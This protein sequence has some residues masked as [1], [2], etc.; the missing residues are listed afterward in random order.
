MICSK[1]NDAVRVKRALISVSDKDGLE[2][3]I[4]ALCE[5]GVEIISTGRTREAI[6]NMGVDVLRISEFT[7]AEEMMD[8]RVKTLHPKVHGAILAD[9]SNPGHMKKL[10]EMG[11]GPIDM[12]VV[13][14]YP[15]SKTVEK[16][17]VTFEEACENIDIGGPT[18]LRSAAKNCRYVA[19]VSR[20]EQ[21]E[22][23]AGEI[24]ESGGELSFETRKKLAKEVF[25]KTSGYDKAIHGYFS[26]GDDLPVENLPC[27][28]N[29]DLVKIKQLRYGENPHQEAAFYRK[30]IQEVKG[31]AEADQLHGKELSFNNIMDIDAAVSIIKPFSECAVSI[32]KHT[33]PCGAAIA[34]DMERAFINALD[35]DRMSAFGGIMAFNRQFDERLAKLVIS[36]SV[37]IECIA[38]P[39]FDD[40]AL[41]VLRQKKNLRILRMD[42]EAF[43]A[44]EKLE[45]KF[46]TGGALVQQTDL[47]NIRESDLKSVTREDFPKD[48]IKPALFGW[49][50]IKNVKSNAIL[51]VSGTKT[52]GIGAGQ[53]SRVDS[54]ALAIKK[55]GERAKG[56]CLISDAFFP[57]PDSVELAH[58][59]GVAG[60]VQ[61]GGS[62]KDKEVIDASNNFRIP[63]VMTGIRHFKH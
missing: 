27:R 17:N 21:Y 37:F 59:A 61:T 2:V 52:V 30:E 31:L 6:L 20:I 19:A 48:L 43:S 22:S 63:M 11:I 29:S 10:S 54:V 33:N 35:S 15:F 12:V 32:V 51:L 26:G 58:K 23:I 56:S 47:L 34:E 18:M 4:K 14:L 60:I 45:V 25:K 41:E 13:N 16:R 57:H 42:E 5:N 39:G 53:M 50:I 44:S 7:S 36:E 8:G 38:A 9:R 62:I 49:K 40:K 3:L 46:V 24:S 55:A 1:G 28:I